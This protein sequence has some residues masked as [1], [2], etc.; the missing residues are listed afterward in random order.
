MREFLSITHSLTAALDQLRV[1][2]I[3]TT[4]SPA[5]RIDRHWWVDPYLLSPVEAKFPVGASSQWQP[6]RRRA[7]E[8]ING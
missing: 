3:S 5:M 2:A 8:G 1:V 4:S 7:G 6:C